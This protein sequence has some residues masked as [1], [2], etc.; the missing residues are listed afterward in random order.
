MRRGESAKIC[1]FSAKICV[2]G[3]LCHL[4]SVTSTA[5]FSSGSSYLFFSAGK[6]TAKKV[7]VRLR[8]V[9]H[10]TWKAACKQFGHVMMRSCKDRLHTWYSM[11]HRWACKPSNPWASQSRFACVCLHLRWAFKVRALLRNEIWLIWRIL[12]EIW[13]I[14]A[15]FGG[16]L[17]NFGGFWWNLA[18]FGGIALLRLWVCLRLST[19]V[20]ICLCLLALLMS[21]F[22]AP[23]SACLTVSEITIKT[24]KSGFNM[25]MKRQLGQTPRKYSIARGLLSNG[26]GASKSLVYNLIP[27]RK[28]SCKCNFAN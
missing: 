2:S 14:L 27:D 16:N 11:H 8:A 6:K 10:H 24:S 26:S 13:Q 15:N 1:G 5:L 20:C 28:S 18:N 9:E 12:A 21:L 3:S 23:P 25:P 19:F 17:A 7:R 4:R 22:V